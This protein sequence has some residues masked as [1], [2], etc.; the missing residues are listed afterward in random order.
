VLGQVATYRRWIS[1]VLGVIV[2]NGCGSSAIPTRERLHCKLQ[3]DLRDDTPFEELKK[4]I[5]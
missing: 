1:G 5:V 3:R 4:S 2:I